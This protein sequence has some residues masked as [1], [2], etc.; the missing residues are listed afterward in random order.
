MK[1]MD[2]WWRGLAA[3]RFQTNRPPYYFPVGGPGAHAITK[4]YGG[5]RLRLNVDVEP[6][7]TIFGGGSGGSGDRWAAFV[8]GGAA[9][10]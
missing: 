8:W 10:W 2:L 1:C 9:A 3:R 7:D 6:V 5:E 4:G